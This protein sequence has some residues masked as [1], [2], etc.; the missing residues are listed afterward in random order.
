LRRVPLGGAV[1]FV[2][3]AVVPLVVLASAC[4]TGPQLVPAPVAAPCS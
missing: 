1:R 4:S 2:V 3:F